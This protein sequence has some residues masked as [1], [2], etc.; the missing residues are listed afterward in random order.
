L[1]GRNYNQT[2]ISFCI[3]IV[4]PYRSKLIPGFYQVKKAAL[5]AGALAVTL[6]G[7]GP[8]ILSFVQK[9]NVSRVSTAMKNAFSRAGVDSKILELSIDKRGAVVK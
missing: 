1:W 7:A 2:K 8:T 6:S 4:E 3:L 9:N 5:S